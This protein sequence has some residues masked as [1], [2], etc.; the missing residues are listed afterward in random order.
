MKR[1]FAKQILKI[2]PIISIKVLLSYQRNFIIE[3]GFNNCLFFN[4]IFLYVIY[5]FRI[6]VWKSAKASQSLL[7]QCI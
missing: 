4:I 7:A 3:S 1:S 5:I 6:I 2:H